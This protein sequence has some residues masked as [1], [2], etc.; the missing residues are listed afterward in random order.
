[1]P[2]LRPIQYVGRRL[3]FITARIRTVSPRTLYSTAYGKRRNSD[4]ESY[5]EVLAQ[6][7]PEGVVDLLVIDGQL[8]GVPERGPLARRSGTQFAEQAHAR[9]EAAG[10]S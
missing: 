7:G 9:R 1:M 4:G 5:R 3:R 2:Q 10:S 6:L 8:L